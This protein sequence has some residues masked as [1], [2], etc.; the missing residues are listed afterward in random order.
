VA[1]F[2]RWKAWSPWLE[3]EPAL[4]LQVSGPT[5]AAGARCAWDSAR[6]GTG[7]ITHTKL[8]PLE[9]IKQRLAFR[10]PF[11]FKGRTAWQFVERDGHTEVTWSMRGRVGF[12]MRAFAGTVQGMVA[13]DFRYG[14]DRLAAAATGRPDAGYRIAYPGL[15]EMPAA[16]CA[17][18]LHHGPLDGLAAA[19]PAAIASVRQQLA[20]AGAVTAA[21]T[22]DALALHVKTQIKQRTTDCRIG[23]E[24]P[25]DHDGQGLPLPVHTLP[26]HRAFVV[27]LSGDLQAAEIAWY[28]AMQRMRIENIEPDLRQPPYTRYLGD[29]SGGA[30][31]RGDA[32]LHIVVRAPR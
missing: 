4:A 30:T 13:L 9:R 8:Q 29:P 12:S 27:S 23:V 18:L 5:A 31:P 16:R 20:Q 15:R 14:L 7:Q 22:G 26:A 11:R 17:W 21:A 24:L 10:Q 28:Q 1:D 2:E 3:H 6:S 19:V 25:D 32:E